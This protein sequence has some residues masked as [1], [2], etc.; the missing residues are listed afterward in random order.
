M[1][2]NDFIMTGTGTKSA[3][4]GS[5]TITFVG[6]SPRIDI[7]PTNT[8]FNA[9]TSLFTC[10]ATAANLTVDAN[11]ATL[12]ALT[13]ETNTSGTSIDFP[14]NI[15]LTNLTFT[16]SGTA[17]SRGDFIYLYSGVTITVTGTLTSTTSDVRVRNIISNNTPQHGAPPAIVAAAVSLS[18]TDFGGVSCSGVAAPFTG[19][20]IG[21]YGWGSTGVTF[22]SPKTVYWRGATGIS[23]ADDANVFSATSGAAGANANYPLPQDTVIVDDNTLATTIEIGLV[24]D[25]VIGTLDA[26]TR[27]AAINFDFEGLLRFGGTNGGLYYSSAVTH[28]TA[29]G[30]VISVQ[31]SGLFELD[32]LEKRIPYT[33]RISQRNDGSSPAPKVKLLSNFLTGY[34]TALTGIFQLR[35]GELDLNGYNATCSV[36]DINELAVDATS[37]QSRL[38]F[39]GGRMIVAYTGTAGTVVAADT[40]HNF[41]MEDGKYIELTGGTGTGSMTLDGANNETSYTTNGKNGLVSVKSKA[42]IATY[43]FSGNRFNN[44]DFSENVG[45]GSAAVAGRFYYGDLIL[46]AGM[47]V[48]A[49][50]AGPTFAGNET[51]NYNSAG[52]TLDT[53][54]T[55]SKTGSGKVV[56]QSNINHTAGKQLTHNTGELDLNDYTLEAGILD[57]D[58]VSPHTIRFNGGILSSGGTSVD[59]N[60]SANLFFADPENGTI[61]LTSASGGVI[62]SMGPSS[63]PKFPT[64]DIATS[65][66]VTFS[67]GGSQSFYNLKNTVSPATVLFSALQTYTF[68]NFELAGTAG[69]LVTIDSSINA[70]H[71]LSKSSGILSA[72]YLSLEFSTATGGAS[73]Y[74]GAN[75]TN[76]GNNTGW[77]FTAAPTVLTG[78]NA[79]QTN[80]STTGAIVVLG[81]VDLTGNNVTQAI[82]STTGA[83]TQVQI[84]TGNNVSQ[85]NTSSADAITQVQTLAGNNVAQAASSAAGAISQERNVAGNGVLQTATSTAG[86]ISQTHALAGANAAQANAST[87]AAVTISYFLTGANTAQPSTVSTGAITQVHRLLG[88]SLNQQ[89]AS[90]AGFIVIPGRLLGQSVS[91]VN[92]S[93]QAQ[94][95]VY[96]VVSAPLGQGFTPK[97]VRDSRPGSSTTARPKQL[98]TS[99]ESRKTNAR[100]T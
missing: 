6:A 70:V 48:P 60:P 40:S 65:Q 45:T 80:Q 63:S 30:N 100:N 95:E 27:T 89:N 90:N 39:N 64:I 36:I 43:N 53:T 56:L 37:Q 17:P 77:S 61:R 7:E 96:A 93:T 69:N 31:S 75:S 21:D 79:T 86:A 25:F 9:G 24:L 42:N 2:V 22:T 83:I 57:L 81:I 34:S 16:N 59:C 26:R 18:N 54:L 97:D 98:N 44:I 51:S 62:F 66:T 33:F 15:T 49:S 55:I 71:T 13:S 88:L 58:P 94:I 19:T 38:T 5:S 11:G 50:A 68:D 91:Q 32:T 72:D 8:T 92:A 67:T 74:A 99:R 12:Y 4:L 28:P 1:T 84:L 52:V 14:T 41:Y 3:T 46:K 20:S 10:P 82:Q 78:N 35:H 47:T 73:W 29:R 87:S 23:E 85:N 76:V